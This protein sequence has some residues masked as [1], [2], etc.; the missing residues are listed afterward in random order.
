MTID[1]ALYSSNSD[2]WATPQHLFDQLNWQ[3]SFTLDVCATA[4]NAKC[5]KYFTKEDNGLIQP[6][7]AE[8]C[9]MN[10]PYSQIGQWIEKAATEGSILD[11]AGVVCLIPSRTDTRYWHQFVMPYAC[12]IAFIK[13]RLKFGDSKNSAPFPSCLVS[14][15]GKQDIGEPRC[16]SFEVDK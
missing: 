8:I 12:E 6:W 2:E 5:K 13:G 10:P 7:T 9:W 15:F 11:R 14:F 16:K 4:S 1:Q 3:E